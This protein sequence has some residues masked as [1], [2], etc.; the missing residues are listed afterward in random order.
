MMAAEPSR[1]AVRDDD[2]R[3][4][5]TDQRAVLHTGQG[6]VG[7]DNYWKGRLSHS[8]YSVTT[9]LPR[10]LLASMCS[11]ALPISANL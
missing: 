8:R 3:K 5:V 2:Q 11:N 7:A 6:Y 4:L 9:I 10:C 1:S